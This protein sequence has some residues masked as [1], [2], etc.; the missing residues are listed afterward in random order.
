MRLFF[1][2]DRPA[3]RRNRERLRT[4]RLQVIA[5]RRAFIAGSAVVAAIFLAAVA[6]LYLGVFNMPFL[7]GLLVGAGA[8]A[9]A[10]GTFWIADVYSGSQNDKFGTYGEENTSDI[11]GSRRMRRRGWTITDAISFEDGDVD[12]V[13]VGPGGVLVLESKW[14]NKAWRFE[15]GRLVLRPGYRDPVAQALWAG[16]K[17]RRLLRSYCIDCDTVPVVVVWGP[18][19][20]ETEP[21]PSEPLNGV[22]M[23]RGRDRPRWLPNLVASGTPIAPEV[24][25]MARWALEDYQ[26]RCATGEDGV[27]LTCGA[28]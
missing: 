27:F 23:L 17:I 16:Q 10:G 14:T 25:A 20:E 5:S 3:G 15:H 26:R 19:S 7:G 9:F 4:A 22:M 18:G 13:A 11:F 24:R 6:W 21:W 2:N 8:A 28:G 1:V 12:H